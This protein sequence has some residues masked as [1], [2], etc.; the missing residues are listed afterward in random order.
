MSVVLTACFGERSQLSQRG[1][2]LDSPPRLVRHELL[3]G[4]P[5][6]S[7]SVQGREFVPLEE[8]EEMVLIVPIPGGTGIG[9]VGAVEWVERWR[10]GFDGEA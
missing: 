5:L 7:A 3:K 1:L 6:I 4:Y 2:L 8:H 9:V 10:R